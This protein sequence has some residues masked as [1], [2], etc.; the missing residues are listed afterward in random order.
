MA[1]WSRADADVATRVGHVQGQQAGGL[2]GAYTVI[3]SEVTWRIGHFL[4]V[5]VIRSIP[6]ARQR[7]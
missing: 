2:N 4:G 5:G 7:D 1:E 6:S 3:C